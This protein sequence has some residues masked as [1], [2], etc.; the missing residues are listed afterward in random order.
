MTARLVLASASPRRA[1]VLRQLGLDFEIRP[2]DIDEAFSSDELPSAYVERLAREK[3]Q[4]VS[5]AEVGALVIGGDTIVLDGEQLLA[6]P[7]SPDDAVAMLMRLSG[8]VHRVLS[9]IALAGPDDVVST[10]VQTGVRMRAFDEVT[11]RAYVETGEPLDKA[12]AYGIQGQGA[13]LVEGIDGDYYS[14]VGFPVGG[15]LDLLGQIG[16][17]FTFRGLEPDR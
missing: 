9:G 11:A 17:R 5:Q 3:A 2:A 16:W 10:V 13:A 4:M 6:K 14:V 7:E 15:F 8:G 1:D 12:G